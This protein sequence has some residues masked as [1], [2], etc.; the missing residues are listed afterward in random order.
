MQ[1]FPAASCSKLHLQKLHL[2]NCDI[3]REVLG[4]FLQNFEGQRSDLGY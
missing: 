3:R 1:L 2:F 4:V